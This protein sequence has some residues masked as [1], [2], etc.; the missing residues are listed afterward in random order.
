[1]KFNILILFL[2]LNSCSSNYTKLDNRKP[3]NSTGLAYIFNIDDYEKKKIPKKFD[4]QQLQISHKDLNVGTLIKLINPNSKETIVLKN[5]KK[6]QYPDFYKILITK[7]V[8]LKLNLDNE[9]PLIEVLEIKKNKSFIAKKAKI[10]QEEKKISSKAPVTSVKIAN[11]SKKKPIIK[12]PIAKN[13]Y[14]LVASFYTY[15][16]ANLLNKRIIDEIPSYDNSKITI[17]KKNS[18]K[19]EVLSGPYKSVNLLKNDYIKLKILGFEELEIF[20]ND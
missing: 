1:M 12:E 15:E 5:S 13:I 16:A 4:N 11:I 20:I 19:F 14:V 18:K 17:K 10:Y 8:A 6:I 7:S 3:Y 9:L 2:I